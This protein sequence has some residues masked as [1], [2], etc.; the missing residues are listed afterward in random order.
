MIIPEMARMMLRQLEMIIKTGEARK[1]PEAIVRSCN[2]KLPTKMAAT[3]SS[4]VLSTIIRVRGTSRVVMRNPS[5]SSKSL[6]LEEDSGEFEEV[7]IFLFS[8]ILS[9]LAFHTL[10]VITAATCCVT[11]TLRNLSDR[12]ERFFV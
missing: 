4:T 9:S 11:V 7:D 2:L 8:F 3:T 1:L 12:R 6:N 10:H 5:L